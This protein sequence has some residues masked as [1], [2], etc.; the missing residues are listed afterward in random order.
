MQSAVATYK[1]HMCHIKM[2]SITY[3]LYYPLCVCV[4]VCVYVIGCF[5]LI[6]YLYFL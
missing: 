5:Y 6:G 4:W 1:S 2:A 3:S